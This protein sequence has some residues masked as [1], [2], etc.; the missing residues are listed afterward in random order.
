V[1]KI[2]FAICACS[3]VAS[4]GSA[5]ATENGTQHY[6]I[7]VNTIA[8]GNLPPPG[9]LQLLSYAQVADSPAVVDSSGHKVVPNFDLGVDAEALRFLYTFKPAI[10]PWHYT[11][12][13]VQPFVNLDLD[14]M[15]TKGHDFN[16]GDLDIQNYLG[17][18]SP[19]HKVFYSFGIDTYVP[20]GHYNKSALINTGSNYYTIAPN[21]NLTYN[22]SPKWELTATLFSEFNTTNKADDYHS[23]DDVD[24]DYGVTYRPFAQMPNFGLGPQGYFYKQVTN[25]RLSGAT[26]SPDGNR[27]QEFAVGPQLRY[28]IPFGAFVLK[29]QQEYNVENRPRGDKVWFQFA[30]PLYGT[31]S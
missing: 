21:L 11:A 28:D 23:G 29:Y 30:I 20:T 15:G 18:V 26:V 27:G 25:D 12:G 6:P 4:I 5:Q 14:V 17:Y 9:M 8:D 22:P 19:D 3:F 16:L 13:F 2:F 7:G 10:G 24:V 1:R 31:P